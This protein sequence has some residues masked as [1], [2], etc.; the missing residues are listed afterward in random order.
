MH[1]ARIVINI[2]KSAEFV[3][4]TPKEGF[5]SGQRNDNGDNAKNQQKR[6]KAADG[7]GRNNGGTGDDQGKSANSDK[8][9]MGKIYQPENTEQE[10][11]A[12]RAQ[13]IKAAKTEGADNCLDNIVH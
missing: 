8:I 12:E 2:M 3:F 11:D 7:H 6:M 1:Q 9:A 4:S 5:A 10:A 13:G